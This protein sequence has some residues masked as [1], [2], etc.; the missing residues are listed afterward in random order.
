MRDPLIS[1]LLSGQQGLSDG[2]PVFLLLSD[3]HSHISHSVA[4]CFSTAIWIREYKFKCIAGL[5]LLYFWTVFF[6]VNIFLTECQQKGLTDI[7]YMKEAQGRKTSR[8]TT[9]ILN[10]HHILQQYKYTYST[11]FEYVANDRSFFCYFLMNTVESKNQNSQQI[12]TN[13]EV[14]NTGEVHHDG[15]Q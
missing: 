4:L 5:V 14:K 10:G 6:A 15:N 9:L 13:V 3:Q 1:P 8:E 7:S 12:Q 2:R 11:I